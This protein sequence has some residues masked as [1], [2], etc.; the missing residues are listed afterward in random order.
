MEEDEGGEHHG[1][2]GC[3][4]RG[5]GAAAAAS[6]SLFTSCRTSCMRMRKEE[7]EKKEEKEGKNRKGRKNVENFSYLKIFWR[8]NDNL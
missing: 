7:R 3:M 5:L 8:K 2:S 1:G 4:G 6:S